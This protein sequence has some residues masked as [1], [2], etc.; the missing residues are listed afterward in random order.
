VQRVNYLVVIS[1]LHCGCR[2][3][4]CPPGEIALDGGG[5][6]IASRHQKTVWA[7]WK[8]FWR[9]FI[10]EEI[11]RGDPYAVLVNGDTLDGVHHGS[12]SQISHN[13]ND[14]ANIAYAC[15]KPVVEACAGRFYMVRGTEVHVGQSGCQEEA[16]A[17]RLG[18]IPD[19]DG[20]Y[21]RW[22]AWI[23]LGKGLIHALHHVGTTGSQCYES[24]AVMKELAEA[25]TEAGRWH[26][27][28]PDVVVRSHRHRMIEVRVP[29]ALGYGISFTTPAWQLKTP[30]T[31]RLAGAR[32]SLPQ[33]GGS[34]ICQGPSDLYTRHMVG[35]I[36]R[37]KVV[38]I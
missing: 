20:N 30:Y 12:T 7:F 17:A 22:E 38:V 3:G 29:T 28:P 4:L 19:A 35:S 10:G 21:A 36:K 2:M 31:Y 16:L 26:N 27:R 37:S 15:L 18:A 32:Q 25:Y 6:Y 23:K 34:V 11:T 24:T 5:S 14:Q 1:D 8:S 13:L 9:D 33:I